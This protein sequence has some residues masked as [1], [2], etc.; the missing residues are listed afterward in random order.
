MDQPEIRKFHPEPVSRRGEMIAW[1]SALFVDAV[2]LILM[3]NNQPVTLWIP[4]LAVPLTLI[5]AV[6]SLGNWM[7]RRTTIEI[8]QDGIYF[9]NG[10]R[11]IKLQWEEIKDVRV[12]PSQWGRKIQVFGETSYFGFHT[13]GEVRV[14]GREL[15]RTG[16]SEGDHILEVI[17][18]KANLVAAQEVDGGS[19]QDGYYYYIR[20]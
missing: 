3:L 19:Q 11:R 14:N 20:K 10:L 18:E 1:G 17:L 15:G 8:G 12:L 5:A 4:I 6:M 16:F 7:E 9:S 2:W 13:L